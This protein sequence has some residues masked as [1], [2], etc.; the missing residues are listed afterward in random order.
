MPR[1]SKWW[2]F[3]RNVSPIVT[4]SATVG[5]LI[6]TSIYAIFAYKQ[7]CTMHEQFVAAQRAA[8]YLGLPDGSTG[9]LIQTGV[10]ALHFRNYGPTP[11]E[12]VLIEVW[13]AVIPYNHSQALHERSLEI[14]AFQGF[15]P[16]HANRIGFPVPPGFPFTIRKTIDSNDWQRVKSGSAQLQ[17]LIRVSYM[18][19][20]GNNCH[21]LTV[22]YSPQLSKFTLGSR[23]SKD[24]CGG[25][26]QVAR[27][28]TTAL[29]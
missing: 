3:I 28:R 24:Y 17:V 6:A 5:I 26:P 16:T 18:D 8:I 13:P 23:P 11:A 15:D 9:E 2:R 12:N 20:F 22:I 7:W 27:F 29:P 14:P 1:T 25:R 10:F 4:T 21:A 19:Q